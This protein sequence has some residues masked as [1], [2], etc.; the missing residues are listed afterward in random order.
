MFLIQWGATE[1]FHILLFQYET[2]FFLVKHILYTLEPESDLQE[3][4]IA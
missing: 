3:N 1:Q 4:Y 2:D